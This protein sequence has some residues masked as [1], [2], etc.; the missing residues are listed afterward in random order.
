M[1]RF[2]NPAAILLWC[3]FAGSGFARDAAPSPAPMAHHLVNLQ[4]IHPPLLQ[5]IRYATTHNFTGQVL[6][7]FPAAFV[8]RDVARALQKIQADLQKEGLGL[9]IYDG[10]R[11]LSIQARMWKL[12]PD[13]RYVSNPATSRGRHARG[14]AVDITLVDRLGNEL[15]MPSNYDAF[16]E[17]AHREGKGWTAEQRANSEKLEAVMKKHGFI[18]YPFEWWH[19]DWKN[20][21]KYPPL[22]ISFEELA[23]GKKTAVPVP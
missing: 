19:F 20:W 15:P 10:Y 9:K 11:P 5:E 21:E 12:V 1:L 23:R 4:E 13:E 17:K 6:Y 8:H 7:P 14:T 16:T 22:D 2:V 18:P 3:S